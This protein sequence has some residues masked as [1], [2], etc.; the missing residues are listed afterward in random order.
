MSVLLLKPAVN[1]KASW[2]RE[3]GLWG[4]L[5]T[6]VGG[7]S[8]VGI[9]GYCQSEGQKAQRAILR[10]EPAKPTYFV[11]VGESVSWFTFCHPRSHSKSFP[12][13]TKQLQEHSLAQWWHHRGPRWEKRKY[14]SSLA[15]LQTF[16]K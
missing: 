2:A 4:S 14:H 15:I 3:C 7:Q 16:P 5:R 10:S 13:P 1:R 9:C 6:T 8:S 11:E 12:Q